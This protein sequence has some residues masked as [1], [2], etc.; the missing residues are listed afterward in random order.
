MTSKWE[1]TLEDA[2]EATEPLSK[3]EN[4]WTS[5]LSNNSKK[6]DFLLG[7]FTIYDYDVTRCRL[8][9]EQ[10]ESELVAA[11]KLMTKIKDSINSASSATLKKG[12]KDP[13]PGWKASLE[14]AV[15]ERDDIAGEII[16]LKREYTKNL[17]FQKNAVD[18]LKTLRNITG[19]YVYEKKTDD[20]L[21]KAVTWC[22]V[23]AARRNKLII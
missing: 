8:L 15:C 19:M 4:E 21:F 12:V 2:I 11:E 18:R 13:M 7:N 3:Y 17:A 5:I 23:E 1:M 6:F 10:K 22:E 9:L 20:W 16:L 14:T